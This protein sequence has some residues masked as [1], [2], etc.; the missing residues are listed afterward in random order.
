M[1]Y[2][3]SRP[4]TSASLRITPPSSSPP[5]STAIGPTSGGVGKD[6]CKSH[7]YLPISNTVG[8]VCLGE[9]T[10]N[11]QKMAVLIQ[12][13]F[14]NTAFKVGHYIGLWCEGPLAG[15]INIV[16]PSIVQI[17]CGEKPVAKSGGGAGTEALTALGNNKEANGVA[18]ITH[19]V[20]GDIILSAP[21]G[22]IRI[23]AKDIDLVASGTKS[24]NGFVTL[25]ASQTLQL[26]GNRV[27][28]EAAE[29]VKLG[30]EREYGIS[31]PGTYKIECGRLKIIEG[32]DVSA[33]PSGQSGTVTALGTFKAIAKLIG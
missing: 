11:N 1:S 5:P 23:L 33:A 2:S 31:V 29:A 32:A 25:N 14:P 3:G 9:V 19:A 24:G 12:N 22:R 7:D 13:I 4:P 20:N 18:F 21:N 17:Y 8:K 27:E 30:C 10:S 16:S 26:K 28:T 15:G 6:E